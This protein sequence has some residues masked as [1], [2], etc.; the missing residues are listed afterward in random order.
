MPMGAASSLLTY[1]FSTKRN[2]AERERG[3]SRCSVFV[4]TT[5]FLVRILT[6]FSRSGSSGITHLSDGCLKSSAEDG[7]M[8]AAA[9]NACLTIRSSNEWK[10]ITPSRPPGFRHLIAAGRTCAPVALV[11]RLRTRPPSAPKDGTH[12]PRAHLFDDGKLIIDSD[13]DGLKRASG[14]VDPLA[15]LAALAAAAAARTAD[16]LVTEGHC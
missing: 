8:P 11:N 1:S 14:R 3:L 15:L 6:N 5:G 9:R 13:A 2:L 10:L 7:F 4:A 12:T 16:G